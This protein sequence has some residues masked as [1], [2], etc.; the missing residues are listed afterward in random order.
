MNCVYLIGLSGSGKTVVAKELAAALR[1]AVRDT[2]Y[3]IEKV[4]KRDIATIFRVDGEESFRNME[5]GIIEALISDEED[6]VVATG[7]GLPTIEGMIERMKSSGVLIYLKASV[8]VLWNRLSM[9]EGGLAKRPL[10]CK[11]GKRA[12]QEMLEAR[13]CLYSQAH[14]TVETDDMDIIDIVAHIKEVLSQDKY[15]PIEADDTSQ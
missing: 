11:A 7:G 3:L 6:K 8:D 13:E 14:V 10:L 15:T 2:D 1:W 12:L 5:A 9:E 4:Q